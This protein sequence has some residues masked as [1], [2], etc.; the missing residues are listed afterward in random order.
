MSDFYSS[1][2]TSAGSRVR[3]SSAKPWLSLLPS[4]ATMLMTALHPYRRR[5]CRTWDRRPTALGRAGIICTGASSCSRIS[6]T[7][8]PRCLLPED[9]TAACTRYCCCALSAEQQAAR[10]CPSSMLKFCIIFDQKD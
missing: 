3:S 4:P 9:A 7:P 6:A 5:R 2:L 8:S 1:P 10:C